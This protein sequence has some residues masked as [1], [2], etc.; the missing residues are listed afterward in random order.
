MHRNRSNS[1]RCNQLENDSNKL[2]FMPLVDPLKKPQVDTMRNGWISKIDTKDAGS[3]AT[4]TYN[5][6][7]D[8][9][10]TSN[11]IKRGALKLK[12][13]EIIFKRNEIQTSLLNKNQ[14]KKQKGEESPVH[15]Y[16][17]ITNRNSREYNSIRRKRELMIFASNKNSRSTSR[18][19]SKS[20]A[21]YSSSPVSSTK[22]R[23]KFIS[24]SNTTGKYNFVTSG[25]TTAELTMRNSSKSNYKLSQILSEIG[26]GKPSFTKGHREYIN[27][28]VNKMNSTGMTNSIHS[29]VNQFNK[30]S[31]LADLTTNTNHR[32]PQMSR[33]VSSKNLPFYSPSKLKS[34][35]PP[36]A[37]L[38][39][40][41][42]IN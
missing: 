28:M 30:A 27:K 17:N 40:Q 11:S 18:L 16:G 34:T 36:E 9:E 19:D 14:R 31:K 33:H 41:N 15:R 21:K 6:T 32:Q 26:S 12:S 35:Q 24:A 37:G 20:R 10:N 3:T 13:N 1:Q 4:D 39:I 5:K 23:N 25:D 8:A 7:I 38:F 42:N 2:H 22:S 29:G